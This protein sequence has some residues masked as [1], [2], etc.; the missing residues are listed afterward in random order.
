MILPSD[1]WC[2]MRFFTC[3][4]DDQGVKG[5][6]PDYRR[7]FQEDIEL[8]TVISKV[9]ELLT[10]K[11]YSLKDAEQVIKALDQRI[12]EDEATY[13]STSGAEMAFSPLDLLKMR[14][15]SDIIIQLNWSVQNEVLTYTIEAFDAYTSK[16]IATS[17]ESKKRSSKAIPLQIQDMIKSHIKPFCDDLNRHF[18]NLKSNGREI[19]IDIRV[20]NNSPVNLET[21]INGE[22]LLTHIQQWLGKNTVNKQFM[23]TDASENMATLEQV[24]IP[25]E[26]DGITL[27]ARSFLTKL[28]KHLAKTPFNLKS[29]VIAKGLGRATII[30]GEE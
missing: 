1:N 5:R 19:A 12:S 8:N 25:L 3:S 2:T 13:S 20:W 30:I 7:A 14:V 28:Q 23:I 21:E 6:H 16:R 9:G 29:K 17:S 27:D 18:S 10:D 22:E 26:N 15:K 24:R 4:Y 11:G